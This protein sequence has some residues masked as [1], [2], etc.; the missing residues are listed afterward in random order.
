[1]YMHFYL[2]LQYPPENLLAK[3]AEH[4]EKVLAAHGPTTSP[5]SAEVCVCVC[6][7]VCYIPHTW[8]HTYTHTHTH[9]HT[10]VHTHSKCMSVR[11]LN[12]SS[13]LSAHVSDTH[14]HTHTRT[15]THTDTHMYRHTAHLVSGAFCLSHI[16]F[17]FF[18]R[19]I[20]F[21]FV[22]HILW[23]TAPRP[24]FFS[25]FLFCY[26]PAFPLLDRQLEL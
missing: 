5:L 13:P 23:R 16:L 22:R 8:T 6:V 1:M 11:E 17:S 20:L 18:L 3:S 24:Q 9:T 4:L 21:S 25:F 14:T 7:C 10:H 2:Y 26:L 19:H 15:H 12:Q